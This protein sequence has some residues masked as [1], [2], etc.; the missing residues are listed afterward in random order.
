M[1]GMEA[2]VDGTVNDS[3][4]NK[5]SDEQQVSLKNISLNIRTEGL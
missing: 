5:K 1:S 2:I 4:E 3:E